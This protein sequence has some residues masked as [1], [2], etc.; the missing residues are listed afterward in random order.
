MPGYTFTGFSDDCNAQGDITVALG[1][2]K[3]C[4]I[5]NDDQQAYITVIKEVTNNN[6]GSAV[7]DDFLLTLDGTP[8]LSGV[9]VPVNP[10]T[11]TASET[12]LPG[13]TFT[14]FSDDCNA[15]GDIT[16]ALGESKTCTITNN[17]NPVDLTIDKTVKTAPSFAAGFWTVVYEVKVKNFGPW[18]TTY[19]LTD[20]PTFGPNVTVENVAVTSLDTA[21]PVNIGDYDWA[22]PA[23]IVDDEPIGVSETDTF[24]VTVTFSVAGSASSSDLDCEVIEE[25]EGTGTLNAG[26]ASYDGSTIQDTDCAPVPKVTIDKTVTNAPSFAAGFWSVT[27]KVD[28][29]NVGPIATTYDLTDTPTFRP[30]VT[31]ENVAVTS[32]DTALPVNIGDYDW[33][34]PALIVDDEPIGVGD[35][36]TFAVTVTFSVAGSATSADLD[37][38]VVE[39]GE[40]APAR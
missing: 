2:S 16:V 8:V 25:G 12:L 4:T 32:L 36:H 5:T 20:T 11:Y 7:A 26:F 38:Q 23:L 6:G 33:A 21:L 22:T 1:E 17:D 14:G 34:T 30:N 37:C 35:T 29:A 10:D 24:A 40:T 28:V 15:Q 27:Y 13:Y 3:T 39:E 31:V 18:A 19:D 9:A